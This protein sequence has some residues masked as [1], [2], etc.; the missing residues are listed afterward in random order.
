MTDTAI[1]EGGA[2]SGEAGSG[3]RARPNYHD[4]KLVAQ[5]IGR[6][7]WYWL[8]VAIPAGVLACALFVLAAYTMTALVADRLGQQ[9]LLDKA[10]EVADILDAANP[11]SFAVLAI[12]G[13]ALVA[14]VLGATLAHGQPL[15]RAFGLGGPFRWSDFWKGAGAFLLLS[16]AGVAIV[17]ADQGEQFTLRDLPQNYGWLLIGGLGALFVQTLGEEMLF[18]AYL[19]RV[20]GG[21]VPIRWI[22][23]GLWIGIFVW[24]HAIN[25]DFAIDPAY[26]AILFVVTEIIN[27]VLFFYTGSIAV[28]W[29]VHFANNSFAILLVA[30][31]PQQSDTMALIK[32]LDPVYAKGGSYLTDPL[33]YAMF[34]GGLAIFLVLMLWR[35]S[36][37]A[38]KR[39]E[40]GA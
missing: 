29:G 18:R 3:E 11:Y 23:A 10:G 38:L 34:A 36:P 8:F 16:A 22:V 27:Y 9:D 14:F 15:S 35:R 24:L 26:V 28:T 30:T 12:Y 32:Y 25:P 31:A 7:R 21:L 33:S 39:W 4:P 1:S 2:G 20:F 37:L 19:V 40:A 17:A 13:G 6:W 5:R